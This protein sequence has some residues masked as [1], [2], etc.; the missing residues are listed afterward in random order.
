MRQ[1]GLPIGF[2]LLVLISLSLSKLSAQGGL[3]PL[4]LDTDGAVVMF[5][6]A[7]Q[8]GA[9]TANSAT[10]RYIFLAREGDAIRITMQRS[11]GDLNPFL[12]LTSEDGTEIDSRGADL[13]GRN[14]VLQY[15]IPADGWYYLEAGREGET[16]GD[17]TGLYTLTLTGTDH[18]I[19]ELLPA[20]APPTSTNAMEILLSANATLEP[21]QQYL[22]PLADG[23]TLRVAANAAITLYDAEGTVVAESANSELTYTTVDA[24]WLVLSVDS[25]TTAEIE[26]SSSGLFVAMVLNELV[27]IT[28]SITPT[29]TLTPTLT[30]TPTVTLTPIPTIPPTT[31]VC[32][33]FLPLRLNVGMQARIIDVTPGDTAKSVRPQPSSPQVIHWLAVGTVLT[34]LDG[35]ECSIAQRDGQGVAWWR[36][37]A[38]D[39]VGWTSEGKGDMYYLEPIP[40]ELR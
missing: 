14:S 28:P 26:T 19:Y 30:L 27:T 20:G 11:E 37:Q 8:S 4:P 29:F 2:I 33:R 6:D 25:P 18:S 40:T 10:I 5:P 21:S 13:S 24:D 3:P 39:V 23:E 1:K 7:V 35:P 36:I 17:S 16:Q 15:T 32:N 22:V 9:I 38:G 34:V 31:V 12:R